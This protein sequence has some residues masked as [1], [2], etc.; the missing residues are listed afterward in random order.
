[1]KPTKA[2]DRA[3]PRSINRSIRHEVQFPAIPRTRIVVYLDGNSI[4]PLVGL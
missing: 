3:I 4:G 2:T 1:M